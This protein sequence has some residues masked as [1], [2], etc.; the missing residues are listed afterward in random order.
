[1]GKSIWTDTVSLPEY[2]ALQGDAR[3]DVLIVGGGLCGVLCA[4]LLKRAG[5]DCMLVEGERIAGGTTKNTTAKLTSQHGL[6]YDRM[7]REKGRERARI[8]LE[9]NEKA[10]EQYRELCA[11][12]PCGYEERTASVY[13]CAAAER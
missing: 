12:I 13:C 2:E 1:M 5:V 6:I 7:L 3:T 10:L 4:F 11:E 8:Y 9:A